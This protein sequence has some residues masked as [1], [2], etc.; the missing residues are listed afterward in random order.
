MLPG[1]IFCTSFQRILAK[2][3]CIREYCSQF[4]LL[5]TMT[6]SR[7]HS[8]FVAVQNPTLALDHAVSASTVY[9]IR[10]LGWVWGVSITSAI[11]QNTLG[12]RLPDALSGVPNK[13]EVRLISLMPPLS[14]SCRR[15]R[16]LTKSLHSSVACRRNQAFHRSFAHAARTCTACRSIG[17]L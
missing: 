6:V 8:I 15:P 4:W 1:S 12:S 9:L 7:I 16:Q 10:S 11:V 5:S 17:V 2:V 3:L 14:I 13:W